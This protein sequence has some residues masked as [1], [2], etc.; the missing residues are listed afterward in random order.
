MVDNFKVE[1]TAEPER[2]VVL[3]PRAVSLEEQMNNCFDMIQQLLQ[4]VA[5]L[6]EMMKR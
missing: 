3:V 4:E 5:E 2:Q 6:K 1:K